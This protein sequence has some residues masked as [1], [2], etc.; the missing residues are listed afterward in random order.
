MAIGV[1]AGDYAEYLPFV[2]PAGGGPAL[3]YLLSGGS[4]RALLA[5]DE[6]TWEDRGFAGSFI[7]NGY[8][9]DTDD[10]IVVS[11]EQQSVDSDTSRHVSTDQAVSFST[12]TDVGALPGGVNSTRFLFRDGLYR[13]QV[14]DNAG[15]SGVGGEYTSPDGLAPW[16]Q[17]GKMPSRDF[18]TAVWGADQWCATE[19]HLYY[20]IR[21]DDSFS[22][23]YRSVIVDTP[24]VGSPQVDRLT[25]DNNDVPPGGPPTGGTFRISVNGVFTG[26]IA[27]NASAAT[28]LGELNLLPGFGAGGS[29]TGS[30]ATNIDITRP[31]DGIFPRLNVDNALITGPFGAFVASSILTPGS[32]GLGTFASDGSSVDPRYSFSGM[33]GSFTGDIALMQVRENDPFSFDNIEHLWKLNGAT[34]I[35]DVT[36]GFVTVNAQ[37]RSLISPDGVTWLG[38]FYDNDAATAQLMRS[39]DSGDTWSLVGPVNAQD[40]NYVVFDPGVANRWWMIAYDTDFSTGL[41]YKSTDN[42]ATWAQHTT[43]FFFLGGNEAIIPTGGRTN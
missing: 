32:L 38:V 19:D 26:N 4:W 27:W 35:A 40:I 1:G 9:P 2:P 25:Y 43:D 39:T 13:I 30:F 28:I 10:A 12:N 18:G 8:A 31:N 14:F 6:T 34:A 29:A 20:V 37:M 16:T 23:E 17:S 41:L 15:D 11:I 33:F 3:L 5:S 24:S 22:G 7:E 36:P 42:G 21:D